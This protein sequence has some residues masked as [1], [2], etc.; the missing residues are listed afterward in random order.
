MCLNEAV[1]ENAASYRLDKVQS[2]Y[3]IVL[4]PLETPPILWRT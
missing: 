3:I 2:L 1:G 4:A